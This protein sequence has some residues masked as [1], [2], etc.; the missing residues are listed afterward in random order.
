MSNNYATKDDLKDETGIDTSNLAEKSDLAGLKDEVDKT[1]MDKL[2][3][4]PVDL[5]KLRN[6]VKTNVVEKTVSHELV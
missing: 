4:V 2:Q 1:D 6:P 3:I 5:S